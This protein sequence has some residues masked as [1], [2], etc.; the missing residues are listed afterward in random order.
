MTVRTLVRCEEPNRPFS[1][2]LEAALYL[3]VID[4]NQLA[5]L[6][7]KKGTNWEHFFFREPI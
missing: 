6:P 3:L 1:I 2:A 5:E 4:E 7:K